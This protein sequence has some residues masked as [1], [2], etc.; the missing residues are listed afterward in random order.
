M[1][2]SL[3]KFQKDRNKSY[4]RSKKGELDLINKSSSLPTH[5]EIQQM[6]KIYDSPNF[7][8]I[9]NCVMRTED[10]FETPVCRLPLAKRT[11]KGFCNDCDLKLS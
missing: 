4:E 2:F 1:K 11:K 8:A 6:F 10:V 5:E 3:K 9:Y 7:D